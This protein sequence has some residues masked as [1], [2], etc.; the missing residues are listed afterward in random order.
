MSLLP[1]K[2]S[3]LL[4]V[5][6]TLVLLFVFFPW[7]CHGKGEQRVGGRHFHDPYIDVRLPTVATTQ[8]YKVSDAWLK[9]LGGYY[10][11]L[12]VLPILVDTQTSDP[13]LN[14][15]PNNNQIRNAVMQKIAAFC[16]PNTELLSQLTS[17]QHQNGYLAIKIQFMADW[18]QADQF[19]MS[20]ID[21]QIHNFRYDLSRIS[22]WVIYLNKKARANNGVDSDDDDEIIREMGVSVDDIRRDA[23]SW[24]I[25]LRILQCMPS[26]KIDLTNQ[27]STYKLD[28]LHKLVVKTFDASDSH[29]QHY[30]RLNYNAGASRAYLDVS[31]F[32]DIWKR[33]ML[34][35]F[36]FTKTEFQFIPF[37]EFENAIGK[38]ILSSPMTHPPT[39]QS[40]SSRD[41]RQRSA[42][43]WY[44]SLCANTRFYSVLQITSKAAPTQ[45]VIQHVKFLL[46]TK[47]SE[48]HIKIHKMIEDPLSSNI[49]DTAR[50]G[51]RGRIQQIYRHGKGSNL[52]KDPIVLLNGNENVNQYTLCLDF[53]L[54]K[55]VV[56]EHV[57]MDNR[58][59]EAIEIIG[60]EFSDSAP[61][62]PFMLLS[63]HV[64]TVQYNTYYGDE[65]TGNTLPILI[66]PTHDHIVTHFYM[67]Q[68]SGHRM[69]HLI[70]E[71]LE[72]L[73][74][75]HNSMKNNSNASPIGKGC[76]GMDLLREPSNM[77]L[78]GRK[79]IDRYMDYLTYDKRNDHYIGIFCGESNTLNFNVKES[80]LIDPSMIPDIDGWRALFIIVTCFLIFRR[81]ISRPVEIPLAIVQSSINNDDMNYKSASTS[82]LNMDEWDPIV[83]PHMTLL[84][85]DIFIYGSLIISLLWYLIAIVMGTIPSTPT[86]ITYWLWVSVASLCLVL[87]I[88]LL[89]LHFVYSFA[90]PLP[91]HDDFQ[92]N[93]KRQRQQE[94]MQLFS[95]LSCCS[96]ITR[97]TI[98]RW[99]F[100]KGRIVREGDAGGEDY[101]K[102]ISLAFACIFR[103]I[104]YIAGISSLLFSLWWDTDDS[105]HW[106]LVSITLLA[107]SVY[108]TYH[109]IEILCLLLIFSGRQARLVNKKNTNNHIIVTPIKS[110]Q[111]TPIFASIRNKGN[112]MTHHNDDGG[113]DL[114]DSTGSHAMTIIYF[115]LSFILA[116][117]VSYFSIT[118]VIVPFLQTVNVVYPI[119]VLIYGTWFTYI[120]LLSVAMSFLHQ[121]IHQV[122]SVVRQITSKI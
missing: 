39:L 65:D 9:S 63:E 27:I 54:D 11:L 32:S 82:P 47:S 106:G 68:N 13:R 37:G 31:P 52:K 46:C 3:F 93:H 44:R 24:D 73:E 8:S 119:E 70:N 74:W 105:F 15:N 120:L 104:G 41:R 97:H 7:T 16:L 49:D 111:A 17:Q 38:W 34:D 10:V 43:E 4:I 118:E 101:Q 88:G 86:Y 99:V 53:D 40:K 79:E 35:G 78:W 66:H 115:V 69:D 58:T 67:Q 83:P 89:V 26:R 84:L 42:V 2:R 64:T 114:G 121:D 75:I 19:N 98:I 72:C 102:P 33:N 117:T 107:A 20:V 1:W 18:I 12:D 100:N 113:D 21:K 59:N 30:D 81:A 94:R 71:T 6:T 91:S 92:W 50:R 112:R 51:R 56:H 22:P 48:S 29:F 23:T 96:Q 85:I 87:G 103:A 76:T 60:I 110:R 95:C 36:F 14:W 55:T 80:S 108:M 122:S 57:L 109:S 28:W 62:R 77:I 116:G 90:I 25:M 45:P 61:T 5:I